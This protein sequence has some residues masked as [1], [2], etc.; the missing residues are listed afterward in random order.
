MNEE[1]GD[2][3]DAIGVPSRAPDTAKPAAP[4]AEA[5]VVDPKTAQDTSTLSVVAAQFSGPL[6]PPAMLQG[7]A[8]VF[9]GCAER[10]V[11]MAEA[12]QK[13]RHSVTRRGQVFAFLTAMTAIVGAIVLLALERGL[14]GFGVLLAG[15]AP[16]VAAFI[17]SERRWREQRRASKEQKDVSEVDA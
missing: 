15:L 17:L 4:A 1:R 16:L 13:E 3:S 11:A 12:E 5:E 9:P 7:Y 10:I 14:A 2:E 8:S 6:P